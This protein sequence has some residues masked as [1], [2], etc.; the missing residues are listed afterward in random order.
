MQRRNFLKL[1]V[2]AAMLA[3]TGAV[4]AIARAQAAGLPFGRTLINVMMP[5]G[6]DLRHLFVPDPDVQPE[7]AVKFWEARQ[8]LYQDSPANTALYPDYASLFE[9]ANPGAGLYTRVSDA[10]SGLSFGLH[11]SAGWLRAQFEAGNAA[12]IANTIGSDNRRHDQSQL[13]VNS[14]DSAA[15]QYVYD[16]DGWGGRLAYTIGDANAVAVTRDISV[17]CNGI[18]A[19]N[20]NARVVHAKDTRNFGLSTGDADPLSDNSVMARALGS[21][22]AAKSP[23]TVQKPASWPY[24][25]FLQHEQSLRIFGDALNERLAAVAPQQPATLAGLYTS[26]SANVL[27]DASFGLQCA[28]AYDSF[29]AADLF[30]QRIVSMEYTGWDTHNNEMARFAANV[31]DLFGIGRGLD[32]LGSEL[33]LLGGVRNDIVYA[34]NTDFG[35]QLR[36]NGDSGTDHGRGNYMIVVGPGVNG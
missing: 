30:E 5:G 20:R 35:R 34:F 1:S 9:S 10:A 14:G 23:E 31:G 8:S 11:S 25:K 21:Y 7:Y 33:E 19:T 29:L 18:D 26:G 3:G 32:T 22:Y 13:I 17:F 4:P 6:A 16:R 36:A 27:N 24:R 12:I 15:S 28:N 2:Y